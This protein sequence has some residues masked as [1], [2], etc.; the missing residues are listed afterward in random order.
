MFISLYTGWG[1]GTSGYLCQWLLTNSPLASCPVWYRFL[2][3]STMFVFYY[4]SAWLFLHPLYTMSQA[5]RA[6]SF[7]G[8]IMCHINYTFII[9]VV[10]LATL[11]FQ[12]FADSAPPYFSDLVP[13]TTV[14]IFVCL[15]ILI[16]FSF[17]EIERT[18]LVNASWYI[19]CV[20]PAN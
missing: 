3:M 2:F 17:P 12:F 6:C 1:W 16:S 4:V 14:G 19:C 18:S 13:H 9:I 11:C 5:L 15:Q 8:I 20:S 7:M 10:N